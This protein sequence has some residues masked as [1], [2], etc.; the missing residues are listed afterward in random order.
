MLFNLLIPSQ[1]K[2]GWKFG[3]FF[4]TSLKMMPRQSWPD[5][6]YGLFRFI[7]CPFNRVVL[8]RLYTLLCQFLGKMETNRC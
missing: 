8:V 3:N 4:C 7:F 5:F 1:T 6:K 2:N